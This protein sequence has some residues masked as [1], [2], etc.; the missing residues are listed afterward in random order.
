MIRNLH[1]E[2]GIPAEILI[3]VSGRRNA[4]RRRKARAT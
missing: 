3:G 2:L 4:G 1:N